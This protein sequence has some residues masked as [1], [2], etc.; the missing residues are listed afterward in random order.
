MSKAKSKNTVENKEVKEVKEVKENKNLTLVEKIKPLL[1]SLY[2][3][4]DKRSNRQ[5]TVTL[6]E[7]VKNGIINLSLGFKENEYEAYK[8]SSKTHSKKNVENSLL[9]SLEIQDI[10]INHDTTVISKVLG[11]GTNLITTFISKNEIVRVNFDNKEI[12]NKY[13]STCIND[14]YTILKNLFDFEKTEVKEF[15]FMDSK[16]IVTSK[17]NGKVIKIKTDSKTITDTKEIDMF[18]SFV[19]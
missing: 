6:N 9:T 7:I 19:S 11:S 2:Q 12:T 18:M 1:L 8:V 4:A 16:I 5:G 14:L 17:M 10:M 13:N 3:K 15:N